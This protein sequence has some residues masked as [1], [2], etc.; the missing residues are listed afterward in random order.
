MEFEQPD[1]DLVFSE[2]E[3]IDVIQKKGRPREDFKSKYWNLLRRVKWAGLV[4]HKP[5]SKNFV[6]FENQILQI[7]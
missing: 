2:E 5:K 7:K 6:S 3:N 1:L 4:V